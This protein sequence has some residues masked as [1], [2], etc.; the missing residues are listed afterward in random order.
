MLAAGPIQS[1]DDFAAQPRR[2]AA[3]RRR[4]GPLE[5]FERIAWGLFKKFVLANFI[6]RL[7]LT[8]FHATGPYSLLEMQLNYVWLFLDFSAYSDVAVGIG[9]A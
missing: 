1:Y 6:D 2:P 7:F 4:L 9:D 3:A 5:A 8:G